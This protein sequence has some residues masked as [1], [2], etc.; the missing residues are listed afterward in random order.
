MVL[1]PL[2]IGVVIAA[3]GVLLYLSNGSGDMQG[4]NDKKTSTVEGL[5]RVSSQRETLL[6]EPAIIARIGLKE[7]S[8]TSW[9]TCDVM[10]S[11][12]GLGSTQYDQT[13]YL[14]RY[15]YL[16]PGSST[17]DQMPWAVGRSYP[18]GC[19]R[20]IDAQGVE[21]PI[22][23]FP[24]GCAREQVPVDAMAV[25]GTIPDLRSAVVSVQSDYYFTFNLG[26]KPFSLLCDA[27]ISEPIRI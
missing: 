10:G 20:G 15:I 21:E 27:P 9:I 25:E 16:D 14:T 1:V 19:A 3:L 17:P 12:L 26:C 5:R 7:L 6:A 23:Y 11:G 8:R 4:L 18:R 24:V 13:C 22:T 2:M